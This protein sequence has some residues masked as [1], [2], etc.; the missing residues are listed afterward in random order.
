MMAIRGVDYITSDTGYPHQYGLSRFEGALPLEIWG[1]GYLIAAFLI[2]VGMTSSHGRLVLF[3]H[4]LGACLY[5]A[6]SVGQAQLALDVSAGIRNATAMLGV[7]LLNLFFALATHFK[8]RQY[9]IMR[10]RGGLGAT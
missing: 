7:G 10:L 9:E 2:L 8:L 6:V 1:A 3:G 4:V 5:F